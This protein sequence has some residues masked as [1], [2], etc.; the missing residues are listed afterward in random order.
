MQTARTAPGE[1][2]VGEYLRLLLAGMGGVY[3]L[4]WAVQLGALQLG[5]QGSGAQG[6]APESMLSSY[7]A[8]AGLL[9]VGLFVFGSAVGLAV[10]GG[11]VLLVT[12]ACVA[13]GFMGV[14]LL[15][16]DVRSA[17][18]GHFAP[19]SPFAS[20]LY[21]AGTLM[22]A[23]LRFNASSEGSSPA[24]ENVDD[25]RSLE[26]PQSAAFAAES[27][28]VEEGPQRSSRHRL[29]RLAKVLALSSAFALL[30]YMIAWPA[31]QWVLG[32]GEFGIP[33]TMGDQL[34]LGQE[35]RVRTAKLSVFLIFVAIGASFGSFLH[36]VAYTLPR[37]QGVPLR[38]SACPNCK[39]KIRRLDNIPIYSYLMLKGRCR[40]CGIEIPIRYLWAEL[41][42]GGL[43][44]SFF[45]LELV[46]GAANL[47]GFREIYYTGIVWIILYTKWDVVGIV[48][49]HLFLYGT[50]L[51]ALYANW[52]RGR[53]PWYF[54]GLASA[55]VFGLPLVFDHLLPMKLATIENV[56]P[57]VLNA[58][59]SLAGGVAG[60]ACGVLLVRFFARHLPSGSDDP[61]GAE[62]GW[63]LS[64]SGVVPALLLLG[65]GLGWQAIFG[66]VG[67]A[68]F[69]LG[70]VLCFRGGRRFVAEN[71]VLATL[72]IAAVT[73]QF[74]WES[75]VKFG[76]P[77]W[78]HQNSPWPIAVGFAASVFVMFY[79][80]SRVWKSHLLKVDL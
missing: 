16:D 60:L 77:V 44:A 78:L 76:Q 47:P 1:S 29:A 67:C 31:M 15:R 36:V 30:L 75:L 66:V 42:M 54:W 45:L 32:W 56:S 18:S 3:A 22:L 65:L 69:L 48:A 74:V 13:V 71:G 2:L 7:G 64:L 43:F 55:I 17:W 80:V 41:S 57:A 27:A 70:L 19:F 72:L 25:C 4:Y 79:M 20:I 14:L 11:R 52:Q 34:T 6:S 59:T 26:E 58:M 5:L 33:T 23:A 24:T 38:S 51:T 62:D 46:T 10:C 40:D 49:Y 50:I 63:Q 68:A 61:A 53:M 12:I 39:T 73:H 37:G 8:T 28:T 21:V 9:L 35:V